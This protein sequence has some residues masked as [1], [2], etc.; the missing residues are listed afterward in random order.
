MSG[1]KHNTLRIGVTGGI[2][3]GKS[4]V[5]RMLEER[6]ITI[7][8]ADV[9]ARQVVEPG[10][11]AL[12]S[13]AEHFGHAILRA[14]GSLD[15]AALRALVFRDEGE[16]KWL[17]GL[18]HPLI[19]TETTRQLEASES[20]YCVLSSPL[21]L[22]TGQ[23]KL[24]DRVLLVDTSEALQL[25]RTQQRDSID[26]IAV[27]AIMASQWP[28]AKRQAQADFIINNEGTLKE[29][30]EAVENMHQQFLALADFIRSKKSNDKS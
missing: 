6:G 14:D 3:S 30:E 29:L 20:P 26:A 21:L 4:A 16:R 2:G 5:T 27:G 1:T 13:I 25:T 12:R 8:D 18:L 15:R 17:E 24:V 22:E 7:V 23:D 10:T 19:R 28:R 9:I 11:Q